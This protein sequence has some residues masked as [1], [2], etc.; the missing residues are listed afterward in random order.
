M[1][2]VAALLV[3]SLNDDK[4]LKENVAILVSRVY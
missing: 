1:K 3:P 4:A 2:V